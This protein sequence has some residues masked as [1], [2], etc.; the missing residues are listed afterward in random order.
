[1]NREKESRRLLTCGLAALIVLAPA[2]AAAQTDAERPTIRIGPFEIR[3]RLLFS[4]VGVDYNVFNEHTDPKRDFTFTT[5]P[6]VEVS[7]H[8]G[9]LRV[10]YTSG[11][12]FVYFHKYTSER[13]V[14]RSFSARADLDLGM[15]K[16]F[17][18]MSS[19]HTSARP[20]SE[21]DLRARHHPRTYAGGTSL[22]LASRTSIAF[23]ARRSTDFY[24]D[25]FE[26]RGVD[27][28]K[29]LDNETMGYE[30]SLNLE[31]TPFTTVSLVAGKDRQRF[32]H[33]PVRNADSIRVAPTVTFSPLGQITGTASVGYRRF[34][35]IDPALPD[36]SG[37]VSSGAIGLILGGQY[38]LDTSFT[39]DVRYSYEE[40]LPYYI[41]SGGRAT[42]AVQTAAALDVRFTAGRESMNYR[43][44][45]G[46][47]SP[48]TDLQTVY[49]AGVGYRIAERLRLVL[50]A[51]FTHRTSERDES[52]EYRNKRLVTT[53]NWGALNR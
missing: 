34:R 16:P 5:A 35:G 47:T 29:S 8:P 27:L 14:N 23:S 22:K 48:G 15:L 46:A 49:G 7:V 30:S 3:P 18:S 42:L 45:A 6:D 40:S 41:V 9:R 4:N 33:D 25:G 21:I 11:S 17:A 28:S 37:F 32:D 53:L 24:D 38:K 2:Q 10:A 26:F 36:Y 43:A 52:R 50:E 1:M 19:A 12:E 31:L 39:R 51:E 44:L 13:K 20:N